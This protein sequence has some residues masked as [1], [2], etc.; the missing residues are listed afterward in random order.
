MEEEAVEV[1]MMS[2]AVAVVEVDGRPVAVE[3][4]EVTVEHPVLRLFV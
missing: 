3:V 2:V 1:G 4:V